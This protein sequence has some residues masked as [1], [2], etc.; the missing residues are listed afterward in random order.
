MSRVTFAFG[1]KSNAIGHL[2]QERATTHVLN[3]IYGRSH[4]L[5]TLMMSE[6]TDAARWAAIV[7]ILREAA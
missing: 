1:A 7:R 4:A 3:V 2:A 5:W 6:Y